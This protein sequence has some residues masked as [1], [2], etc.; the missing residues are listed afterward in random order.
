MD[1]AKSLNNLG[2]VCGAEGDYKGAREYFEQAPAMNTKVLPA[3]HPRIK[4]AQAMLSQA[5]AE[6]CL[7]TPRHVSRNTLSQLPQAAIAAAVC[8]MAWWLLVQ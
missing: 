8:S 1:I 4:Q 5:K 6:Q 3:Q 2:S 7:Q